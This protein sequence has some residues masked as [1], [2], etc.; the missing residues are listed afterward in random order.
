MILVI[1]TE[2]F[3]YKSFSHSVPFE[4]L[5]ETQVNIFIDFA[6]S[7]HLRNQINNNI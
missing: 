6:E 5:S 2:S 4:V 7:L 1:V 3:F